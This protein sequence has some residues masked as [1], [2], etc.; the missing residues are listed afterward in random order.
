MREAIVLAGGQGTRLKEVV[1]DLPKPMAPVAG[2]PFL[3]ILL[4]LLASKDFQRV[5]LSLGHMADKIVAHFGNTFAGMELAYEIESEPLGTGGALRLSLAQCRDEHVFVFSGDTYLDLEVTD[6]EALWQRQR[7]PIIV[8][9]AC[10]DASRYGRLRVH[11]GRMMGFAEK[12]FAGPALINAGCY[13]LPIDVLDGFAIGQR[14]SL[15]T[16]FVAKAILRRRFEVFVTKGL[17]IDIGVPEDYQ[18]AQMMFGSSASG[19]M[20]ESSSNS[21]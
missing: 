7:N 21:S 14:F 17:F 8:A 13:V 2:R 4:E 5:V 19:S 1:P 15:E 12:G 9:C 10:S 18:R 6:V 20:M 16:D 3:E 11:E